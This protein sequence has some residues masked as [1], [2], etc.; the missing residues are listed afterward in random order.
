ML[1]FVYAMRT[2]VSA[3]TEAN[4]VCSVLFDMQNRTLVAIGQPYIGSLLVTAMCVFQFLACIWSRAAPSPRASH[5]CH[6]RFSRISL[7]FLIRLLSLPPRT[8]RRRGAWRMPIGGLPHGRKGLRPQPKA[9]CHRRS[10]LPCRPPSSWTLGATPAVRRRNQV[11][12][13]L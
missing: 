13:Q 12:H 7:T 1:G 4:R 6:F 9:R 3:I 5:H 8:A 2:L 10:A 11:P